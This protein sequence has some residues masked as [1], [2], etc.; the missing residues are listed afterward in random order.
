[1]SNKNRYI[2]REESFG[3]ILIDKEKRC[4]KTLSKEEFKRI[5]N[6]PLPK[7]ILVRSK[8][9]INI[10][11]LQSPLTI[12]WGITRKCN[13]NCKTCYSKKMIGKEISKKEA[14]KVIDQLYALGIP[15]IIFG[16]GEPLCRGDFLEIVKYATNKGFVV[17]IDTNG[18]LL[19][20][21]I[22]DKLYSMGVNRVDISLDAG[23]KKTND[24][25]R[26]KGTFQKIIRSIKNLKSKKFYVGVGV[27]VTSKN[28]CSLKKIVF[29]L[30]K[31][32]VDEIHFLK[33]K[34]LGNG[35]INRFLCPNK[36]W[37]EIKEEI[38]KIKKEYP[39][40][41]I[42]LENSKC[43]VMFKTATILP[44]GEVTFCPLYD[45]I[46]S[47]GNIKREKFLKIWER[48]LKQNKYR[49]CSFCGT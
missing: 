32:N 7:M 23:D 26:G 17:D 3:G 18:I 44:E 31:L 48:L 19:N 41:K 24:F 30:N 21:R 40:L 11:G 45:G 47:F 43:G 29:L 16:G 5:L 9:L 46:V 28:V 25:I 20:K 36:S 4:C 38:R 35:K 10:K 8:K 42:Y 2:L 13:L 27:V 12:K 49:D 1:M 22:L 33:F 6:N 14:L 37:E 15:H 39:S 34:L